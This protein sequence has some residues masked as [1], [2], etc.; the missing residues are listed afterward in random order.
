LDGGNVGDN[1][2][3]VVAIK[4]TQVIKAR[5][6]HEL[7]NKLGISQGTVS[8]ALKYGTKI[9]GFTVRKDE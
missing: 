8:N 5:S 3:K 4:D 7:S 6:C 2:T 9:K 1:A